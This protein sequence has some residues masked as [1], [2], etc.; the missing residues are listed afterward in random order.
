MSRSKQKGTS[1]ETLLLPE[2]RAYYPGAERR[3][4]SGNLDKGDFILPGAQF[5]LE[6]K[7][8]K[9]M[10]LGTWV[11][12]AEVEARNLSVR[13]GVVAHKRRGTTDPAR[14]FATMSLGAFLA[15]V[16]EAD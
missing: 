13:Y 7:N 10:S 8:V 11:D 16:N 14:Q 6:A 5:A 3:A 9:T 15:L 2:L 1:F 12:E 4:L